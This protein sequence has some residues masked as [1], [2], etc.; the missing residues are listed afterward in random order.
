VTERTLTVRL[1]AINDQY[2][3]GMQEASAETSKFAATAKGAFAGF[4]AELKGTGDQLTRNVSLPL[5]GLGVAAGK[6]ADNFDQTFAKMVGLAGVTAGEVDGLKQ[7]VLDL[8]SVTGRGPQDL[9][10]GLYF[11]SSAGFDTATAMQIL[12]V[13]AKGATAGLGSTSSVVNAVTN[14]LGA[15]GT[16]ALS[17]AQAVDILTAGAKVSKV[18]AS[19][20]APQLGRLLPTAQA[21]GVGFDQVVAAMGYL[22]QKSGDA[23]LSATQLDGVLR[24]LLVPSEQ[25]RKA[26]D[27]VGL[28]ADQLRNVVATGGLPAALDL[29]KSKFGGNSDALYQLFDDIQAFQG[30]QALLADSTGGLNDA[31]EATR[32]SAGETG[33]AFEAVASTDGFRLRQSLAEAKVALIQI[34][35]AV[36]PLVASLATIGGAFAGAFADLP[37][38]LQSG[39][40][41][42]VALLAAVGPVMSI[43][44]RLIE[45]FTTLTTAIGKAF[46]KAAVGAY[47]AAGS[48]G[49]LAAATVGVTV[50]VA[51]A[52]TELQ[53]Q[54][55]AKAEVASWTRELTQALEAEAAGQAGAAEAAM[56]RRL[57]ERGAI[58][59]AEKLG[60]TSKDL[61]QAL[62]GN[63]DAHQRVYA[64]MK[65][66]ESLLSGDEWRQFLLAIGNGLDASA[67]SAQNFEQKTRAA[68][69]GVA[70]L[71]P[72]ASGAAGGVAAAGSTMAS[73][74]SAADDAEARMRALV[75]TM[76]VLYASAFDVLDAQ[77]SFADALADVDSAG[78]STGGSVRDL[79]SQHRA[80]ERATLDV[81]DAQQ[82]LA[83]AEA[84]LAEARKGPSDREKGDASFRVREAELGLAEAK[85][86]VADAQKR[87][88]EEEK[89]GAKGDVEG[90]KL[91]LRRAELQLE[92][93]QLRVVDSQ[94]EQNDVMKSGEDTSKKVRDAVDAVTAANDRLA[95]ANQRVAD[96]E[97]DLRRE[98]S[99]GGPVADRHRQIAGAIDRAVEAGQ[100]LI[101]KMVEQKRPYQEITGEIDNQIRKIDDLIGRYGDAN[102]KL[103]ARIDL[104]LIEKF[105]MGGVNVDPYRGTT[106]IFADLNR[107]LGLEGRA[108]GGPVQPGTAYMVGEERPEVFVPD[109]PGRIVTGQLTAASSY[110]APTPS[111]TVTRVVHHVE[112]ST[113][114]QLVLDGRVVTEIVVDTNARYS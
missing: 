10:E 86:R 61:T 81:T 83:D 50:V 67:S 3:K 33:K 108:G 91:D 38:W 46:D 2:R 105:L 14:A 51:A 96:A 37:G 18:E 36:M 75:D 114:V 64:A 41:G 77:V 53:K 79:T 74:A 104:L 68:A 70:G 69:D 21:L 98:A 84:A 99:T 35:D 58:D 39:V 62:L 88:S 107:S 59:S 71:G 48:M 89:K 47:D 56:F 72:A 113:P 111:A 95:Q 106:Q 66:G 11:A 103:K 97:A 63:E 8:A 15:Y 12:E 44:G 34:G 90:A 82:G 30:A 4:G 85:R 100:R 16:G 94:A 49:T 32:N 60:I 22:S 26:L 19:A 76:G 29:L 45:N 13:S 28:S 43:T 54:A 112:R 87:I 7:K 57:Q 23:S 27:A 42:F 92:Q 17:A 25:G 80:L 5:L 52:V 65:A 31:F 24:K 73:M 55:R 6:L 101:E 78:R 1:R 110:A 109:V 102:G 40:I 20:L 9:A 93:A